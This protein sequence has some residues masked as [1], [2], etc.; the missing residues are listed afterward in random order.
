MFPSAG[1]RGNVY[2]DFSP[3]DIRTPPGLHRP[4]TTGRDGG[5]ATVV[6]FSPYQKDLRQSLDKSKKK[7]D[8]SS[9][10]ERRRQMFKTPGDGVP[11]LRFQGN[12]WSPNGARLQWLKNV[13]YVLK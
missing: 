5:Q 13:K 8:Q 12:L 7:K 11:K 9:A 10:K 4:S 1:T 6:T 2:F 3:L